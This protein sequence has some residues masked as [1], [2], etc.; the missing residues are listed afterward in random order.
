MNIVK[1]SVATKIYTLIKE[2]HIVICAFLCFFASICINVFW[3][4][5][6]MS[7]ALFVLA[8]GLFF[9]KLYDCFIWA[10]F[11]FLKKDRKFGFSNTDTVIVFALTVFLFLNYASYIDNIEPSMNKIAELIYNED[12]NKQIKNKDGSFIS[13][14][15]YDGNLSVIQ[16]TSN[17]VTENFSFKRDN[18]C[19]IIFE[20]INLSIDIAD[21]YCF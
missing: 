3:V 19:I 16:I 7:T 12:Y 10:I 1:A 21:A 5:M 6:I 13:I 2:K 9:Y 20:P 18:N 11:R 15:L 8:L 4:D 17:R 14:K